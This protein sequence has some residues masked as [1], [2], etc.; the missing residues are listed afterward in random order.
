MRIPAATSAETPKIAPVPLQGT[1]V[2][3]RQRLHSASQ[4]P[5]IGIIVT[6]KHPTEEELELELELELVSTAEC[7][8]NDGEGEHGSRA[9]ENATPP[10]AL[11]PPT[12]LSTTVVRHA[13]TMQ[14]REVIVLPHALHFSP[15]IF[16][17]F[18]SR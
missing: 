14:T 16:F 7:C 10:T 12:K 5:G 6:G 11:P 8:P 13:H 2:K 9:K 1:P 4:Q 17:R 18:L 3:V 15:A